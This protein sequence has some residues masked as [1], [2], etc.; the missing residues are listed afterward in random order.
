M[1]VQ[2]DLPGAPDGAVLALRHGV[3]VVAHYGSV[4]AEM[5]VCRKAA[6]LVDRRDLVRLDV[7]GAAPWVDHALARVLGAPAPARGQAAR[8]ADLW[9]CRPATD[10]AV[11]VGPPA[12]LARWRAVLRSAVVAGDHIAYGA[13]GGGTAFASLVGP[14]AARVM[15]AAG[16]PGDM[17]VG[18]VAA[19]AG[20]VSLVVREAE[21]AFLLGFEAAHA[22]AARAAIARAGGPFGLSRVGN[23]ALERLRIARPL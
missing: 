16:L 18:G 15:D 4:A 17:P 23:D 12:A 20:P 5:A 2:I 22:A 8:A 3:S 1:A 10:L 7:T 19:P 13:T 6:G 11:L 14:R 9:C 21:D